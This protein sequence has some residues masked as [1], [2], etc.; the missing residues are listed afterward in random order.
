[1]LRILQITGSLGFHG[2]EAVVMEYYRNIDREKIQFDFVVTS[3]VPERLDAEVESM[4]GRIFRVPSKSRHPFAFKKAVREIL[5]NN[6]EY[7]IVHAHGNS[8]SMYLDLSSAKKSKIPVRICH[9][10]NTSCFIKWQHYILKP[11]LGGKY[12]HRFAC[13]AAA[14]KWLFGKREAKIIHNAIDLDKFS[15]DAAAREKIRNLYGIADNC[16][17]LGHIGGF[18]PNKNHAFLLS[19]FSEYQKLNPDS[20]LLLVGGGNTEQVKRHAAELGITEK[21]IFAGLTSEPQKYYSAFDAFVFPSLYEGLPRAVIEAAA[22][23][24]P[25]FIS[26]KITREV[27]VAS[28][29]KFFPLSSP[30]DWAKAIFESGLQKNADSQKEIRDNGYDITLAAKEL[31]EFYLLQL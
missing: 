8:A 19:V 23:G 24:L 6:T 16:A 11:L 20:R 7:K 31:Q 9:S 12:T 29:I 2:I 14:G 26:D 22:A 10:H 3:A 5:K 4:G 17:V 1:M 21:V 13:S 30:S 15:F 27:G 18:S 25:C 28:S